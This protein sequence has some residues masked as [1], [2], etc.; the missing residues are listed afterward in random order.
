MK[1]GKAF[2]RRDRRF[3]LPFPPNGHLVMEQGHGRN[4]I[5]GDAKDFASNPKVSS[6][7]FANFKRDSPIRNQARSRRVCRLMSGSAMGSWLLPEQNPSPEAT[8][9]KRRV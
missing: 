1:H 6:C 9:F 7:T 4:A 2:F 3:F 8:G 5:P